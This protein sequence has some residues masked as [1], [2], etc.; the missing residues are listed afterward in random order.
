MYMGPYQTTARFLFVE[1]TLDISKQVGG[2]C[3]LAKGT[4]QD[5]KNLSDLIS[6]TISFVEVMNDLQIETIHI[7]YVRLTLPQD[8]TLV[9]LGQDTKSVTTSITWSGAKPS[10][11]RQASSSAVSA[12][13]YSFSR[14]CLPI[15]TRSL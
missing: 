8:S 15:S 12:A 13:S 6:S 1:S 7:P 5:A 3:D 4:V 14:T 10:A 2:V 9:K 11:K